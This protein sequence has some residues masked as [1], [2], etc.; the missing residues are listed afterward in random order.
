MK[1]GKDNYLDYIPKRNSLLVWEENKN[2]HVE[3]LLH[4][5]GFYNR[6]AQILFKKPKISHIELD[7]MGS[8]IWKNMDGEKTVFELGKCVKERFDKEAEPLYE[9]LST[10]LKTLHDH[11][12]IVYVNLMKEKETKAKQDK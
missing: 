3:L 6:M 9:R 5:K 11:Q 7:D 10:Y 4:N 8:F 12:F 1:A 2:S